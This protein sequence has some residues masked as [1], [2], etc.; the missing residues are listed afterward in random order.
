MRSIERRKVN[1]LGVKFLRNLLELS[2]MNRV[3][4]EEAHSRAGMEMELESGSE[5]VEM[6]WKRLENGCAPYG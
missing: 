1:V 3:I 5:S 6:V 4:N 2:R